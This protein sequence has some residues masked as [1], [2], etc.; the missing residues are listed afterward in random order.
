M[1]IKSDLAS[2]NK[3]TNGQ[4]ASM[5]LWV[6]T[7]DRLAGLLRFADL[8]DSWWEEEINSE[9]NSTRGFFEENPKAAFAFEDQ[10]SNY[11]RVQT[12]RVMCASLL[13]ALN[14]VVENLVLGSCSFVGNFVHKKPHWEDAVRYLQKE[15]SINIESLAGFWAMKRVRLLSNCFKHNDGSVN[16]ELSSFAGL[17]ECEEVAYEEEDIRILLHIADVF[18][19]DVRDHLEASG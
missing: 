11:S 4:L 8:I 14:A 13:S 3:M 17:P 10:E 16:E 12:K 19:A 15:R 9:E 1:D 18:L 2:N 5:W 6:Q 7:G